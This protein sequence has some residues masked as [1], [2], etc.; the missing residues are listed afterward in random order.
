MKY[1]LQ[2]F[3]TLLVF[4]CA[5]ANAAQWGTVLTDKAVIYADQSMMAPIGYI[6]KGQKVRVGE[7]KRSYGKLLPVVVSGKIAYIQVKDI[8]SNTKLLQ[9]RSATERKKEADKKTVEKRVSVIYSGY[10]SFINIDK[11]S[12]FSGDTNAGEIFYFNG[13]GLRGYTSDLSSNSTWRITLDYG[14]TLVKD[15]KFTVLNLVGEYSYNIVQANNYD[16]RLYGGV[17]AVPYTQ[18]SYDNLF[19]VNGYGAGASAGVEMV[20][21]ILDGLGLHLDAGYSYTKLFFRLP[22][23]TNI[24]KYEPSFHGAKFSAGLSFAF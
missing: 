24:N 3:L 19:T 2:I 14:T 18:Y 4:C 20:F 12:S 23:Q 13:G 15:N 10:A 9:L 5:D 16:L 17:I 7:I 1:V 21:K 6:K 8:N 11:D 22:S